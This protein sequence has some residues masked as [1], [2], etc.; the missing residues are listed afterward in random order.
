[1]QGT[2]INDSRIKKTAKTK[3]F[4]MPTLM[5]DAKAIVLLKYEFFSLKFSDSQ[6]SE[7]KQEEKDFVIVYSSK[8]AVFSMEALLEKTNFVV[9]ERKFENRTMTIKKAFFGILGLSRICSLKA[10]K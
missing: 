10:N 9:N 1:M 5:E 2:Q 3:M 7:A 8:S 4:S 6:D